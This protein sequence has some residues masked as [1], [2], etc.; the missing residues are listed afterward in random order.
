MSVW[1]NINFNDFN[2]EEPIENEKLKKLLKRSHG[3]L[4]NAHLSSV[5]YSGRKLS[6]E[7]K[8][9]MSESRKGHGWSDVAFN[10]LKES[11]RKRMIPI[12]QFDLEGNWI[13][14]FAGLAE[15]H[16]ELGLNKRNVQMVCNNWKDNNEKGSKQCGG[17]IWKYK[18]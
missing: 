7:T 3:Q 12:S 14:D 13:K 9:R 10:K 16:D 4:V 15:M 18:N 17:F 1:D 11:A 2:G 5:N 8:K 6:E